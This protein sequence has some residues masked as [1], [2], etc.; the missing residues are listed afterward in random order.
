MLLAILAL[1]IGLALL[2]Y[3]ADQFIKGA[4]A[5]AAHSGIA[6]GNAV[7]SNISNIAL[8]TVQIRIGGF[9]S[10][11]SGFTG[12]VSVQRKIESDRPACFRCHRRITAAG[13]TGR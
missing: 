5:T 13:Q 10:G 1:I 6:P 7:G 4:S 12:M 9:D 8:I 2:V 11:F 3:S